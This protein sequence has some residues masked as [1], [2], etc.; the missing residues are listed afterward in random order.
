MAISSSHIPS[1]FINGNFSL[2]N[3][4]CFFL[5]YLF[6]SLCN[7]ISTDSR[8]FPPFSGHQKLF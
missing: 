5:I 2:G 4:G 1:V 8:L 3:S 7:Y 6:H